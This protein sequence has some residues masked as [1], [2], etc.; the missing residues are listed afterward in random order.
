[1]QIIPA[2]LNQS[3]TDFDRQLNGLSPYFQHFQIDIADGEFVPN[4]T[5]Q[6]FD[7]IN[8]F[9]SHQSP[10]TNHQPPV[11][12]HQYDFHLMVKD[13]EKEIRAIEEL[14][15]LIT[16]KNILIHFSVI[17]PEIITNSS[18]VLNPEDQVEDL[19]NIIDLT[20]IPAIQIMTVIP[21]FQ[22]SAFVP[23]TLKKIGQLRQSGYRNIIMLDGGIS[24]KTLPLILAEEDKPD[25]LCIGS[26]LTN[27]EQLEDKVTQLRQLTAVN[28]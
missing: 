14:K 12:S 1:M 22:G 16:V 24:E 25:V 3:I 18:I 26:Y 17:D 13:F 19:A 28:S 27:L 20:K 11:T 15:K 2:L 9:S 7:L 10:S 23:L 21:G 4:R 5:I 8:Y 6:V